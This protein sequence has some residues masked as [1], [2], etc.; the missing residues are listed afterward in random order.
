MKIDNITRAEKLIAKYKNLEIQL[1]ELNNNGS[2]TIKDLISGI[3]VS[4]NETDAIRKILTDA[5]KR[6]LETVKKEYETL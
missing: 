6:E 1:R 2:Q 3:N 5:V 4:E